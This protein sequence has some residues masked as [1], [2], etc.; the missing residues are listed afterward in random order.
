MKRATAIL[1]AMFILVPLWAAA[2]E[3]EQEQ[4]KGKL[5]AGTF[6]GLKLRCIG[7]ALMSGRI[8]DL[9]VDPTDAATWYVAVASGGVWKTT[10][11]GTT[12]NPIFDNYGTY[13]IDRKSV[14]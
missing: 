1:L 3:E 6:S 9:A 4:E 5:N 14:V 7:P 2:Q 8:S 13:S 11:T 10:N 12:W